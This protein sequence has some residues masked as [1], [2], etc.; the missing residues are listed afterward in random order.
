M[1]TST[2]PTSTSASTSKILTS[3]IMASHSEPILPPSTNKAIKS[4]MSILIPAILKFI[5][6]GSTQV[7]Y[8]QSTQ[9][10]LLVLGLLPASQKEAIF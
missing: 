7:T 1:T 4:H 9:S 10:A 8:M 2:T 6:D 5:E 3:T